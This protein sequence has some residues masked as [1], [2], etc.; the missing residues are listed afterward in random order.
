MMTLQELNRLERRWKRVFAAAAFV[1]VVCLVDLFP[2]QATG[3]E[4]FGCYM[5]G[6]FAVL[7]ALLAAK[8]LGDADRAG[9]IAEGEWLNAHENLEMPGLPADED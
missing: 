7:V 3:L 2:M 9:A 1:L 4:R 6:S 8:R 5:I